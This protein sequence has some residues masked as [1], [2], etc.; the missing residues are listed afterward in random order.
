[1]NF[2]AIVFCHATSAFSFSL[3]TFMLPN[4]KGNIFL[5]GFLIG[6]FEILAYTFSGLMMKMLGLRLQI[7][8]CYLISFFSAVIYQFIDFSKTSELVEASFLAF[9]MFGVAAN[10]NSTAYAGYLCCP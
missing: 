7:L 4:L 2:S 3:F 6:S 9:L 1:M 8:M 5:N 10:C